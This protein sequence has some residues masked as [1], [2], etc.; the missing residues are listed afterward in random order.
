MYSQENNLLL[1]W[2]HTRLRLRKKQFWPIESSL[3]L[4]P[5]IFK[6]EGVLFTMP[7]FKGSLSLIETTQDMCK[8]GLGCVMVYMATLL[9]TL[10]ISLNAE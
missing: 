6:V 7:N 1:S 8:L 3:T 2:F 4:T 5:A 10:T 9:N